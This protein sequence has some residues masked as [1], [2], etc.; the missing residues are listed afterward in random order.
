MIECKIKE[1][2]LKKYSSVHSFSKTIGLPYSTVD[3]ILKRGLLNSNTLN[4]IKICNELRIDVS[5]LA[6][7]KVVFK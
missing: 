3:T 2:I 7:N 1:L 5:E 6:N 4:V